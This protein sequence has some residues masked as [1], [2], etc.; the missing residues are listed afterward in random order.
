MAADRRGPLLARVAEV[1]GERLKRAA[2]DARTALD[3]ATAAS[4]QAHA[5]REAAAVERAEARA[6]FAA[7]PACIQA[8]LWLDRTIAGETGA[9][10]RL[11]DEAA[12][13]DLARDAHG[14]AVLALTRHE[15]RSDVIAEH[16]RAILRAGRRLAEDR[17]EA[18]ATPVMRVRS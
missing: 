4:E 8:R 16:H 9:V 10:A 7:S 12:R 18:E 1:K 11:S 5:D 2:A 17:I 13:L 6:L 15:A 14:A 3:A